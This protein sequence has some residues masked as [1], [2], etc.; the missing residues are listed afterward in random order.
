MDRRPLDR[1]VR[2]RC[3]HVAH[4]VEQ[5][6]AAHAVNVANATRLMLAVELAGAT[7]LCERRRRKRLARPKPTRLG[8]TAKPKAPA[9]PAIAVTLVRAAR[10]MLRRPQLK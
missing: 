9:P 1:V 7:L 3:P 4:A 2:R 10:C 6:D 8:N 5:S